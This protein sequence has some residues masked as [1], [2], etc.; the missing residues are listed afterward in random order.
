[1]KSVRWLLGVAGALVLGACASTSETA[2]NPNFDPAACYERRLSVY[3][4]SDVVEISPEAREAID[5]LETSL[6]GCRI[7]HVRIIGLAG[8]PGT[9]TE[10]M[11][12]SEQRADVVA[13]YLHETTGWSRQRFELLA[14]G[15]E[16]A[17]NE[18]GLDRPMRRRARVIIT[19]SAP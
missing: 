19:A 6:Q 1:M 2:S 15:E 11:E 9:E 7:E 12:L 16:N 5:A 13:D 14:R 18:E 17:Q 3:F 4:E 10:N 8:A